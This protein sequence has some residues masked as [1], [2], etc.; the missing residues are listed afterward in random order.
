MALSESWLNDSNEK[1]F[2]I[3]G[4]HHIVSNIRK[5]NSSRGGVALY[6]RD[7][8]AFTPRPD[9][10]IFIPFVFESSVVTLN[11]LNITIAVVYRSPAV[12]TAA[13]LQLCQQFFQKLNQT[14]EKVFLL[15]D[16]NIDLLDYHS[17]TNV[18]EFIDLCFEFGLLP[19]ITKPTRFTPTRASCLDNIITNASLSREFFSGILIEDISDHFPVF[20][21][22]PSRPVTKRQNAN[23]PTSSYRVLNNANISDLND[24]LS[25]HDWQDIISDNDSSSAASK[26]NVILTELLAQACPL[27]SHKDKKKNTPNQPW[28]SL[29]LK[30][31]SKR[32]NKLFKKALGNEQRMIFYRKY[33]NIYNTLI[34]LAKANYYKKAIFESSDNIKKTWALLKQ[35]IAK[36]KTLYSPPE[37]LNASLK[38]SYTVKL[39]EPEL[40][41]DYFNCFF[42][43]VGERTSGSINTTSLKNPLDY[44]NEINISQSFFISPTTVNEVILTALHIKSKS[45]TGHDNFSNVLIKKI[46]YHIAIPLTHIFNSSFVTGIFPDIYKIA[47]I[48]PVYKSGDKTSASNYRPI[49]LLPA[50][51]KILEKLISKRLFNFISNNN[52]IF[53]GQYGFLRGKSTEHAMLDIVDK[54]NNA[55]ESYLKNRSQ[56]VDTRNAQSSQLPITHGVPQGSILGPL[57]FLLYINDMPSSSLVL[58]F[59]LFADDTTGLYHSPTLDELFCCLKSEINLLQTWFSSNQLLVNAS[60]TNLVIFTTRQK[61]LHLTSDNKNHSLI[62]DNIALSPTNSVKYLGLLLDQNLDFKEH[63]KLISSKMSKGIFALKRASKILDSKDLITL[64]YALIYP[65]LTYGL[66][67]WGGSCRVH[68]KIRILNSGEKQKLSKSLSTVYNLQKRALR[69][70]SGQGYSAH[71]IPLCFSLQILDLEHVYDLKALSFLHDYYH[72][73]VPPFCQNKLMFYYNKDN[74]L[75]LKIQFRRTDTAS[76][77]LFHTLPNIWNSL[78]NYLK[79]D[80]DTS[81][82]SFLQGLKNHYFNQYEIWECCDTACYTCRGAADNI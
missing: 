66:L 52:I 69:I 25:K 58:S 43:T 19:T 20:C 80:I 75:S 79:L 24:K 4:F 3:S 41:A 10:E 40:I 78:P 71:H 46:I 14:K 5:D 72:E 21:Q 45:S 36:N 61:R 76:A 35:I 1:A 22:I 59:I 67:V 54:I 29:G 33:R 37:L 12:N 65:Y 77:T 32:K 82:A 13:S 42:S 23:E 49:S 62:M 7:D 16:Y 39:D 55:I 9:L 63:F 56:Y 38:D 30:I 34:K 57:L 51:S 47:K 8:I 81:K 17:D 74:V 31:S 27:K 26:L 64:Y 44:L 2:P 70:I 73:K 6:I 48:I 60:K 15:R 11:D 53:S 18:S 68:S 50:F 28:F